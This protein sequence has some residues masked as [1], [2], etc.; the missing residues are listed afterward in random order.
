MRGQTAV[1]YLAV[2]SAALVVIAV[3]TAARM[4]DPARESGESALVMAQA[5]EAADLIASAVDSVY[6]NGPGSADG[7]II[8]MDA[9]WSLILDNENSEVEIQ[10]STSGGV[11]EFQAS[12][13]YPLNGQYTLPDLSSGVYVVVADW[14]PSSG[15]EG[16]EVVAENK[17]IQIHINPLEG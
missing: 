3:A 16:I 13:R 9:V 15:G 7:V 5:R 1:E 8:R 10:V 2:F 17:I 11:K 14:P 4:I 6:A 12:L